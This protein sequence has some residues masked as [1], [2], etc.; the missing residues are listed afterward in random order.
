MKILIFNILL[1]FSQSL[2]AVEPHDVDWNS[3]RQNIANHLVE[4]GFAS[5][6]KINGKSFVISNPKVSIDGTLYRVEAQTLSSRDAHNT[7]P[8][9]ICYR[10]GFAKQVQKIKRNF[11]SIY[12]AVRIWGNETPGH[13]YIEDPISIV[14]EITCIGIL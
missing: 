3:V 9:S 14:S 4:K 8:D 6:V 10:L 7:R 1:I 2:F 11:N 5:N 13:Y 12:D